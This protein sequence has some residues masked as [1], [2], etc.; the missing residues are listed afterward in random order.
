MSSIETNLECE[1]E[2]DI[3]CEVVRSEPKISD[4]D[5]I[6]NSLKEWAVSYNINHAAINGLLSILKPMHANLPL[7]ARTLLGTT[8]AGRI[9]QFQQ[10]EFCYFGVKS[11]LVKYFDSIKHVSRADMPAIGSN[12]N[13]NFNIDGI[14]LFRSSAISF[15]PILCTIDKVDMLPL[16]VA[17]YC[18]A[19]K[20]TE[21]NSYLE[22]FVNE[23]KDFK[24]LDVDGQK[25]NI[26]I[27]SFGGQIY[28]V[29]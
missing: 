4:K 22:K 5:F 1:T 20:K 10:G 18:G 27:R 17:I 2:E 3:P 26:F 21:V 23:L 29:S 8:S 15:W 25:Y 13:L 9:E 24:F 16:V 14:P 6:R 11:S 19:K 7:D 12:L 28:R